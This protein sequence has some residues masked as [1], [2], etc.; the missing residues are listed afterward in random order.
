[1][2]LLEAFLEIEEIRCYEVNHDVLG[3]PVK[4]MVPYFQ[5]IQHARKPLLVR[6]SFH[7]EEIRLLMDSLDPRGLFLNIMVED[8][9]EIEQLRP[10]IGM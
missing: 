3:P 7:P 4:A 1:M 2:F 5:R 6:G 8:E 10:L 9:R